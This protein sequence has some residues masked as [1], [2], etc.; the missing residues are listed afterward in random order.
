MR[1]FQE[2]RET[3]NSYVYRRQHKQAVA[4]KTGLCTHCGF[5][6]GHDNFDGYCGPHP[7]WKLV[8]KVP[9]QWMYDPNRDL[10]EENGN[11]IGFRNR[12]RK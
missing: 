8:T 6:R 3:T 7:S 9:K 10:P 12:S 4:N 2:I 11:P 5:H 1:T